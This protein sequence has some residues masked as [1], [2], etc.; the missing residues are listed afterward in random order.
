MST[1]V[2]HDVGPLENS[3]HETRIFHYNDMELR[4]AGFRIHS[5]PKKGS[6]IWDLH[7]ILYSEEEAVEHMKTLVIK[8][9]KQK[10]VIG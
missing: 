2:P 9:S 5:R 3:W 1:K 10:Q 7:G 4:A 8:T 6:D